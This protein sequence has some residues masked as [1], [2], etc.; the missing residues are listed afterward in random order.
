MEIETMTRAVIVSF[1]NYVWTEP[2]K[3][4]DVMFDFFIKNFKEHWYNEVD[5]LY[6]LDSCWDAV[7]DDP[8]V[9]IV[10][11]DQQLRYYEAYKEFLPKIKEDLILF[12][13]NDMVIQKPGIIKHTFDIIELGEVNVVTIMD[14][15]GTWRAAPARLRLGNKFCPY[16]FATKKDLLMKYR[17]ADWAPNMPDY[18]TL[19]DL[20]IEMVNDGLRIHEIEDD[21]NDPPKDSAFYHIRAGSTIPYLITTK[22]SDQPLAYWDYLKNQPAS[23][24]LR[25]CDWWDRMGGDSSEIRKDLNEKKDINAN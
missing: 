17:Y 4:F 18:E 14:T 12:V 16:Y 11:V 7:Y 24:L 19:G 21:K 5:K 22:Y 6:I 8:K 2:H 13:D 9:E 25:H 15:I 1:R 10:K 20:T 23:E 3:Y